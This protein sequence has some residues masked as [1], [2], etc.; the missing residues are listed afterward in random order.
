LPTDAGSSLEPG[1]GRRGEAVPRVG[2]AVV[3]GLRAVRTAGY[4]MLDPFDWLARRLGWG[5]ELPPLSL[6]RHAGPV[7]AFS[8]S[9]EALFRLLLSK[10]LLRPDTRLLD[11]GCGPGAVPLRLDRERVTIRA[12]VGIDVHERSILWC[13]RR[14]A[15]RAE[16]RFEL[17]EV[18][19]PYGGK[20]SLDPRDYA[21]PVSDA[22]AD[23]VL[24]KSL[25]THLLEKTARHYLSEARRCLAPTGHGVLTAF[26]FDGEGGGPPAFPHHGANPAIRWRR[27]SH[28]EAAVAYDRRLFEEMLSTAGLEI[29]EML[30]GFWPGASRAIRG[31]DT[32]IVRPAPPREVRRKNGP[33]GEASR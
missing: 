16:F 29:S 25:F 2:A 5:A 24:A 3:G 13:R 23:L 19:S 21:F 18:R 10:N 33:L 30:P 14:F 22:A 20:G 28:P 8:T 31:Q 9:T 27:R 6:R 15:R 32:Y 1:P 4:R 12:Y 26:V 7:R 17:A 11:L